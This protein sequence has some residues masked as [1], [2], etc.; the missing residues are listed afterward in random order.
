MKKKLSTKKK[1]ANRIKPVVGR[2][3]LKGIEIEV[4]EKG[5]VVW[6]KERK[7]VKNKMVTINHW[8]VDASC[9]REDGLLRFGQKELYKIEARYNENENC[10]EVG[11]L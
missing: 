9:L 2:S 5:F 10:V 3:Y 7:K 1:T 8:V 4:T 11:R 6:V